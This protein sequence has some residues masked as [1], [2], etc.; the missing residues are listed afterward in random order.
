MNKIVKTKEL[1]LSGGEL[2]GDIWGYK[3]LQR[4][5]LKPIHSQGIQAWKT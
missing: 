5:M 2:V 3:V 1:K 4:Q